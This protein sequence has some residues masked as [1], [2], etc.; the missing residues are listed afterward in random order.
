VGDIMTEDVTTVCPGSSVVSATKI[1]SDKNISC[2]IVSD[3][4]DLSGIITGT[5]MLKRVVVEGNDFRKMT[6]ERIMSSPVRSAPRNLS[7]LDA[8]R[9]ME[10]EN[11]RRLIVLEQERVVGIITQ[12]DI[13]RALSSYSMWKD[14]SELMTSDVAAIASSATVKKAAEVMASRDISCLVAMD[15]DAVA[16][17]F[18][19]RDLLKRVIALKRNPAQTILKNVMSSPVASVTS[20]YSIPSASKMMEKMRIHRLLVMDDKTLRGVITQTDILKAIKGKLQEEEE[21]YFELLGKSNNCIYV[22]DLDNNTTYVN[23]AL[24]KLLEVTDPD[25]LINKPFLPEQLWD[26]P[27]QRDQILNQL[28]KASVEVH[29]LTLRTTKGK[30]LFVTLFSTRTKN[31]KGQTT[32]SQGVLYDVTA[33]KELAILKEMEQQLRNSEDL[34]RGTLESTADGILVIDEKG[35]LSHMNKRFAKIWDVPEELVQQRDDERLLE[36]LGCQLEDQSPFLEKL[37]APCSADQDSSDILYLKEGKVLEVYSLPL[38]RQGRFTGRV[39][40]FRDITERKQAE[41][42]LRKAHDE[43]EVRVEQRT[44]ELARANK[45]L[46]SEITERKK[47]GE[48]LRESEEKYKTLTENS[49]TGVFIQQD[50]RYVFVNDRFAQIHSYRPE[51]LLGKEYW[52]LIHPDDREMV[53]QIVSKRLSGEEIMH[54]YEMRRLKKN[55]QAIWCEVMVSRI[56]YKGKPT[57]IGNIIDVTERKTEEETLDKVN[58]CFLSFGP[59]PDKNINKIVETAGLVLEC[60]CALYNKEEGPLLCTRGGWNIPENFKR[61]DNKEGHICYDVININKDEPIAINGLDETPYAQTDPNVTKYKLKTY[62]GCA[63]KVHGKAIGSL[64]IVFQKNRAFNSNELKIFHILAEALGVEEER[65]KAEVVLEKLNTDLELTVRELIRTNKELQEFAYITAHDLKTPLRGIGTLA[66]W[67]STDYA[68]KFDEQ[69]QKHVKLLA[70]RAKRT[71]KLVDSILQYSSAGQLRE[72][73]EQ[74]DLNTVLPE[75]IC[76]IDPPENIEITLDNKLPVLMCKKTHIR[77]VFYNLLSNAVKHM[78]KEKGQIKVGCLE[79]NGFWKFSV[80]DNGPGIDQKYFKKIFK[81]F[82]MLSPT[83]ETESTGIGLSI[84][85]KIVKMNAGRIWV[86]SK[87]GEGSTFFFTVPKSGVLQ[88]VCTE[89]AS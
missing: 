14:V 31:I 9:I 45:V 13:V 33:K 15:N 76:E 64:C 32:G 46:E 38:I 66:E 55:A 29:D 86:E 3:N 10:A 85:K 41:E 23:P 49:L 17:I 63:V 12:T 26:N 6:V 8:S 1:M 89:A 74:V 88:E 56:E 71:D 34:L 21:N 47:A 54:R 7:V 43:L 28:K 42:V 65:K 2:I 5:D 24:M 59:N 53:A 72:E 69:G 62:V 4:G 37:Q 51:E 87:V 81:I 83:D 36:H 19:E 40:S 82:Q 48:A 30:K 39:W 70:E 22:V 78:D 68:D 58:K 16:G 27:H 84:A 44:A 35:R 52:S 57:I 79:E 25:E 60:T 20:N 75:I 80:A 11:I 61:K 67:L 77:Q 18:T 50:G 73:Q